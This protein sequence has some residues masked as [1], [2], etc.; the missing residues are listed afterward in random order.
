MT[1]ETAFGWWLACAVHPHA[2]W[3]RLRPAGRAMLVGTYVGIGY[4][5]A[6]VMLLAV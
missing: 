4:V 2:A 3:R 5:G 1:L 6:L